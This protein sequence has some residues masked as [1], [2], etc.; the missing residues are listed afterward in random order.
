MRELGYGRVV[1]WRGELGAPA[2]RSRES[3]RE[4]ESVDVSVE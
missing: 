1:W 4:G 3:S 2:M